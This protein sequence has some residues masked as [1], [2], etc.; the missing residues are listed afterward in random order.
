MAT[1]TCVFS[2]GEIVEFESHGLT[3]H[4][5][6][7]LR[8]RL[9]EWWDGSCSFGQCLVSVD[10]RPSFALIRYVY[11][12]QMP[13]SHQVCEIRLLRL[14]KWQSVGGEIIRKFITAE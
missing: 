5:W 11:E 1:Y 14:R 9:M 13:Y 4:Y 6:D 2:T 8:R 3:M 7:L 10:G 12:E